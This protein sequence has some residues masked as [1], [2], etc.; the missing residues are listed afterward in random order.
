MSNFPSTARMARHYSGCLR[1]Y[2]FVGL[3]GQVG[4]VGDGHQS[5]QTGT[6]LRA[7]IPSFLLIAPFEP[8]R[9]QRAQKIN[10]S[11]F[12]A[13]FVVNLPPLIRVNSCPF[14]VQN[15]NRLVLR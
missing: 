8:Q 4:P 12:S 7:H 3:V 14:V 10:F 5:R 9:T 6:W 2:Y 13:F 15:V 1:G 11:E